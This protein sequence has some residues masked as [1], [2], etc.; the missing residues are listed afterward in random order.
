[1]DLDTFPAP[2]GRK[3]V[4]IHPPGGLPGGS[5]ADHPHAVVVDTFLFGM[6]GFS[7]AILVQ[8]GSFALFRLCLCHVGCHQWS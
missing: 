6:C 2:E 3:G 7:E 4:H 1:M 8:E 5:L